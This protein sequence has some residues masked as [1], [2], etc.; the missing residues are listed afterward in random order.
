MMMMMM[1]MGDRGSW[2]G[3]VPA[4]RFPIVPRKTEKCGSVVQGS[5]LAAAA[6]AGRKRKRNGLQTTAD[7][8][9]ET[10]TRTKRQPGADCGKHRHKIYE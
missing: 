7:R 2:R 1:M 9:A 3:K 5:V 8:T 10:P 6:P 4:A